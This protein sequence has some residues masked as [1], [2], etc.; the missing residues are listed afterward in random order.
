M[1]HQGLYRDPG[2]VTR[3]PSLVPA[4]AQ[5]HVGSHVRQEAHD[6]TSSGSLPIGLQGVTNYTPPP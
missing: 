4:G 5:A 1:D 3:A 2:C 6:M